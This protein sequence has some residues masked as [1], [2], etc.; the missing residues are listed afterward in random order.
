MRRLF[1]R[2]DRYLDVHQKTEHPRETW[3]WLT[4]YHRY[5]RNVAAQQ[6]SFLRLR[7]EDTTR[8]RKPWGVN[9]L[10]L[11]LTYCI[12][13]AEMLNGP[14]NSETPVL[15][16]AASNTLAGTSR[17]HWRVLLLL[18]HPVSETMPSPIGAA[19]DDCGAKCEYGTLE[20]ASA[21]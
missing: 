4:N 1:L 7:N 21:S 18:E 19:F 11:K 14:G 6:P 16:I 17:K 5:I 15:S 12:R 13:T 10:F 8:S 9:L 2:L 20:F 3:P